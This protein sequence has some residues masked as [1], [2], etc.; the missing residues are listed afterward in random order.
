MRRRKARKWRKR[1]K[2]TIRRESCWWAVPQLRRFLEEQGG[3][4][5]DAEGVGK[6]YVDFSRNESAFKAAYAL[7]NLVY[8]SGWE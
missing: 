2:T 1:R 4:V 6:L 8:K 5:E 7:H 3:S